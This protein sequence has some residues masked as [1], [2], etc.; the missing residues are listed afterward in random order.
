MAISVEALEE[1]LS[2]IEV[3]ILKPRGE[4]NGKVATA[5]AREIFRNYADVVSPGLRAKLGA[6]R[7]T[8]DR[9]KVLW[10]LECK[11]LE[12]GL[13]PGEV[14]VLLEGTVWNKFADDRSRLW[15]D[16][17]KAAQKVPTTRS[18]A[19][20]SSPNG[21]TQAG[22]TSR[23]RKEAWAVP[24]ER[25][26]AV[27][28]QDPKWMVEGL[29]SD[30]SHGIIA[31]EPKTRKS[32]F[33][34][35]LAL[36]VATGTPV[37]GHFPVSKQGPVLMIQE[38]ISDAEMRKRL[39]YIA[40][41]KDL[42]GKVEKVGD[43]ISLHLPEPVPFYLRN[44]AGFDLSKDD[45]YIE[46]EK[47]IIDREIKLL[48]LDPLQMMLGTIDENQASQVRP[49]LKNLLQLK[50]ATGAGT[51][52][53]HHHGKTQS[54]NPRQGGQRM[55]GSQALHGWTESAM[56]LTRTEDP[57]V[58]H[59]EREFRNFEPMPPF[60][61]EY[62]GGNDAYRVQVIEKKPRKPMSKFEKWCV[63]HP[64][65]PVKDLANA[66]KKST[67]TIRRLVERSPYLELNHLRT[68]SRGRPVTVV[69]RLKVKG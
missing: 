2:D 56:Y 4:S 48:I 41:G 38:E 3:P 19:Q 9:S 37:F 13:S 17:G 7:T 52:I 57:A 18:R 8:G 45:S 40:A 10:R 55:L 23:P 65:T 16:V 58:T 43:S 24:L 49:M 35:D 62:M 47:E 66:T 33:A 31:G 39:R 50:E 64:N 29:W 5:S 11:L 44:R 54:N 60:S 69:T 12:H 28:S 42:G 36:S 61:V 30:K 21:T 22:R 20:A 68:G 14:V 63:N 34:I 26:L 32:Y 25:Y 46:L 1:R 6:K 67:D 51:L 15:A 53:V 27:E 59:S